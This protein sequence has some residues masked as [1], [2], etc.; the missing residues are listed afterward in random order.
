MNNIYQ[1]IKEYRNQKSEKE[2]KLFLMALE[3]S[4]RTSLKNF[5]A[6]QDDNSRF[7]NLYEGWI[8]T[9]KEEMIFLEAYSFGLDVIDY[10]NRYC[11]S[12]E[13]KKEFDEQQRTM[14]KLLIK[15]RQFHSVAQLLK[16][17]ME[18]ERFK[19]KKLSELNELIKTF[20]TK[21]GIKVPEKFSK[22]LFEWLKIRRFP[23]Y[24]LVG[25]EEQLQLPMYAPMPDEN[26]LAIK[27][28]KALQR[29][30]RNTNKLI[31]E[32]LKYRDIRD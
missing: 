4:T 28:A 9:I 27:I 10:L 15:N 20:L 6:F 1:L 26:T 21:R 32:L 11:V 7:E 25:Y 16:V 19:E 2:K 17:Q 18:D 8:T 29:T 5:I 24:M 14:I 12:K 22:Q 13:I 3:H 23:P 31:T 30:P